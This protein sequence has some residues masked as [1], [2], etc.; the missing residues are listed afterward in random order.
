[1]DFINGNEHYYYIVYNYILQIIC[2]NI[3]KITV[4]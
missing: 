3:N 2:Y 1:M 4:K